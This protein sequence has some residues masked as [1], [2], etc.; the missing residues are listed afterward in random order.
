M[1]AAP[2]DT[3]VVV[4]D[5]FTE[6]G[7]LFES[8]EG[9]GPLE[10]ILGTGSV[11]P[12]FDENIIGMTEGE[13]KSFTLAPEMA[14]GPSKPELIHTFSLNNIKNHK[15]ITV[16]MVIGMDLEHEGERHQVP[17]LVTALGEKDIT[18]DFNHPMAGRTLT[19]KTTLQS[20]IKNGP[21]G[22]PQG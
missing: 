3:V 18:V 21:D 1:K 7:E 17:A 5:G 22:Q 2:G 20:I 8:S 16:G 9:S 19:F 15:D 11:L 14:H 13:S 4:Y 10:F 6:D 12:G